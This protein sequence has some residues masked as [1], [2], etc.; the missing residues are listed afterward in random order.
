MAQHPT[1]PAPAPVNPP[2]TVTAAAPGEDL[3][4]QVTDTIDRYIGLVRDR[5]TRPALIASRA[6]VFGL[7]LAILG[8]SA[9]V[10]VSIAWTTLITAL[11]K[12]VWITH[13]ITGGIFVL[14]GA[15]L[16]TKRRPPEIEL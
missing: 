5:T 12:K 15:F 9:I 1:V 16:M 2:A 7:M 14:L 11:V 3:A 6:L 8:I 4:A 13:F 10:L